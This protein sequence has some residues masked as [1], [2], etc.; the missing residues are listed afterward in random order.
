MGLTTSVDST[1]LSVDGK[2]V[3]ELNITEGIFT[4]RQKKYIQFMFNESVDA[5]LKGVM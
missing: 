5:C 2:V 1:E 3:A 4:D